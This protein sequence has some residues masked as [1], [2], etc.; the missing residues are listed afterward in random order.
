[1]QMTSLCHFFQRIRHCHFARL[2]WSSATVHARWRD[3]SIG[4]LK[5][6]LLL[7]LQFGQDSGYR[8]MQFLRSAR[9]FAAILDGKSSTDAEEMTT[10][11]RL[12]S[13]DAKAAF[14]FGR[15]GILLSN[16]AIGSVPGTFR[17]RADHQTK[18]RAS[19]Y[20]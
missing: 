6:T 7:V 8:L 17:R 1:M 19:Q 20:C 18:G 2:P 9:S 10:I 14:V 15:V 11:D 3:Q 12:A 13:R 4:G 16:S 5:R